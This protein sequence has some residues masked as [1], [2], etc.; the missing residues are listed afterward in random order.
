MTKFNLQNQFC[1]MS[2]TDTHFLYKSKSIDRAIYRVY[3]RKFN[4]VGYEEMY[5]KKEKK[6]SHIE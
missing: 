6:K 5:W 1:K 3:S 2:Y 4:S